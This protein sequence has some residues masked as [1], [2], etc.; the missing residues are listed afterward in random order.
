MYEIPLV[1]YKDFN[2]YLRATRKQNPGLPEKSKI[3]KEVLSNLEAA[4]EAYLK[5]YELKLK[6][7]AQSFH[8]SMPDLV[9]MLNKQKS[10][11]EKLDEEGR[12]LKMVQI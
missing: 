8:I 3:D 11:S 4:Y 9:K 5:K 2:A 12:N 10:E 7:F 6:S 1:E